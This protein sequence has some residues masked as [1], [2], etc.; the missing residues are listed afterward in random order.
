MHWCVTTF[1][2][3]AILVFDITGIGFGIGKLNKFGDSD[4]LINMDEK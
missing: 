3:T 2:Y 1:L 4:E